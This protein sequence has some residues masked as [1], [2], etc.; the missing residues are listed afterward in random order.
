MIAQ[1]GGMLGFADFAVLCASL[2]RRRRTIHKQFTV[3]FN[4]I[5]RTIEN[6]L[7]KERIPNRILGG[8]QFFERAEVSHA[9]IPDIRNNLV[10][11]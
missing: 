4:A 6:A 8:H 10:V 1:S 7:Q 3:R 5:S 2:L 9:P 11:D